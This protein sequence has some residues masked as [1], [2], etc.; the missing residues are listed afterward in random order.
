MMTAIKTVATS[1]QRLLHFEIG[2]FHSK[3][4]LT[5]ETKTSFELQNGLGK[6]RDR[7]REQLRHLP[8]T[9]PAEINRH[10]DKRDENI[11]ALQAPF[12][13]GASQRVNH[14]PCK[15]WLELHFVMK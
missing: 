1:A 14:L 8:Q 4:M 11:L 10:C 12:C 7:Y 3:A 2:K 5:L 6:V 13:T 15:Q 9:T